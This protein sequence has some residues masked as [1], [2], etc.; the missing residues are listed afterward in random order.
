[1]IGKENERNWKKRIRE[2]RERKKKK[3]ERENGRGRKCS[4]VLN[5]E[6]H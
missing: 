5:G 4:H 3:R 1:M 6:A 2:E